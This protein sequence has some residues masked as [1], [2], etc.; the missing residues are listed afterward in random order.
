MVSLNIIAT[1]EVS[2][3]DFSISS[4][5]IRLKH[6]YLLFVTD[7]DEF[8]LGTIT[9]ASQP[10]EVHTGSSSNPFNFFGIKNNMLANIVSKTASKTLKAPVMVMLLIKETKLKQKRIN[11]LVIKNIKQLLEELNNNDL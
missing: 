10:S 9:L 1:S 3:G 4:S 11:Q 5:L 7:Q 8:G 6:S 2:H